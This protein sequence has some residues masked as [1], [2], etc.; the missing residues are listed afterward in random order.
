MD[1][2]EFSKYFMIVLGIVLI[3]VA[4]WE[5]NNTQLIIGHIWLMG[6]LTY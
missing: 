2:K 6:G 3:V 5:E 1:A 4:V